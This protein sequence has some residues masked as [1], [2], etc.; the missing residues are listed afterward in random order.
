[1]T[2]KLTALEF[3]VP[4]SGTWGRHGRRADNVGFHLLFCD[5]NYTWAVNS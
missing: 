1:M 3:T 4:L 5:P 2:K